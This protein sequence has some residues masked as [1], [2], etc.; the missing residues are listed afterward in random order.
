[1][2]V[3]K[4]LGYLYSQ[5]HQSMLRSLVLLWGLLVPR[6]FSRCGQEGLKSIGGSTGGKMAGWSVDFIWVGARTGRVRTIKG[7]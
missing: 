1:M 4:K 2:G 6:D 5:D 3:G 7:I